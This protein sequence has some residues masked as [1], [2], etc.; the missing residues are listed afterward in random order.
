MSLF[1][2]QGHPDKNGTGLKL[3]AYARLKKQPYKRRMLEFNRMEVFLYTEEFLKE[4]FA[5]KTIFD[6]GN[7]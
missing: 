3:N 7:N 5:I 6:G 1:D 4:F 2:Y